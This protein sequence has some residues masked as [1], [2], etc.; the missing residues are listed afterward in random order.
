MR[1]LWDSFKL[2]PK[3]KYSLEH[4]KYL[5][6]VLTKNPVINDQNTGVIVETLRQVAELL[7]WGDQNNAG[8]L[9][10]FLEKNLLGFFFAIL[11]Q[12]TSRTVQIQLMQTLSIL[13]ENLRSQD[14]LF[15]LFSNN[16]INKVIIHKF[17]FSDEELLAYY[18]S[19]MKTLS[20]K[21]DR[22]TVQFFFSAIDNDFPLYT[23]AIKFFNHE[24]SMIRIAVRTLTLNVFRVEDEHMRRYILNSTAV[25]YFANI[26]WFV[27][28]QVL[29]LNQLVSKSNHETRRR[30]DDFVDDLLDQFYYTHDI[31]NLG[32]ED[33]NVVLSDHLM[34]NLMLPLLVGSIAPPEKGREPPAPNAEDR[35][36]PV[37]ALF[38]LAQVF[39]IYSYKPLVNTLASALIHPAP[40]ADFTSLMHIKPPPPPSLS[41]LGTRTAFRRFASTPNLDQMERDAVSGSPQQPRRSS[42]FM[43]PTPPGSPSLSASASSVT[44]PTPRRN[45]P[46]R[47]LPPA[48]SLLRSASATRL[49]SSAPPDPSTPSR[50]P[51]SSPERKQRG[52]QMKEVLLSYFDDDRT[53]LA[54]VCLFYAVVKNQA[55]EREL[56]EI[57][58]L[59]PYRLTRAKQLLEILTSGRSAHAR[60]KS[61]THAL[62]GMQITP[63]HPVLNGRTSTQ[64]A[65]APRTPLGHGHGPT[66]PL[67]SPET[68]PNK[69]DTA[70]QSQ[71]ESKT[72]AEEAPRLKRRK[73]KRKVDGEPEAEVDPGIVTVPDSQQREFS[74]ELISRLLHVLVRSSQFRLVTLQMTLLMLKELVYSEDSPP[75]LTHRQLLLLGEAYGNASDSIREVLAGTLGPIFLELFEEDL[76]T[77]H[78]VN[79]DHL[80][81]DASLLLPVSGTSGSRLDLT[82]RLPSGEAEKTQKAIQQFL[83]LRELKYALL[84]KRDDQ[85]PLKEPPPPSI[86]AKDQVTIN[87]SSAPTGI[88]SPTPDPSEPPST[89]PAAPHDPLAPTAPSHPDFTSAAATAPATPA[90]QSS[91]TTTASPNFVA[92]P[93]QSVFN[94]TSSTTH[95]PP[96]PALLISYSIGVTHPKDKSKRVRRFL[97]QY[98]RTL[99]VVDPSLKA[100]GIPTRIDAVCLHVAPLQSLEIEVDHT[101][102]TMLQI[103]SH[104]TTWSTTMIFDDSDGCNAAKDVLERARSSV[105]SSKM[106]QIYNILGEGATEGHAPLGSESED[107]GDESAT[108][109]EDL[110]RV[111]GRPASGEQLPFIPPSPTTP[112]SGGM[113]VPAISADPASSPN[114][115]SPSSMLNVLPVGSPQGPSVSPRVSIRVDSHPLAEEMHTPPPSPP[116]P[117]DDLPYEHPQAVPS[118]QGEE[119]SEP[120]AVKPADLEARPD[121]ETLPMDV[122]VVEP[123]PVSPDVGSAETPSIMV[124][125]EDEALLENTSKTAPQEDL[126]EVP[127]EQ[128]TSSPNTSSPP[129]EESDVS[130]TPQPSPPPSTTPPLAPSTLSHHDTPPMAEES[131]HS[132]S[133]ESKGT[134]SDEAEPEQQLEPE[135]ES[136]PEPESE[137]QPEPELH[138]TVDDTPFPAHVE[139]EVPSE[140]KEDNMN[141]DGAGVDDAAGDDEQEDIQIQNDGAKPRA[142]NPGE[143]VA[144]GK[145]KKKKGRGGRRR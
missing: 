36:S 145:K 80:I 41:N 118:Y 35:I 11:A 37:L 129:T 51:P 141:P 102:S 13:V 139:T 114:I 16:H 87:I 79:F 9:D 94:C 117:A 74:R 65:G 123:A 103:T 124:M 84:R 91:A 142:D 45:T 25:P 81:K 62:R 138:P 70:K 59:F 64:P 96:T 144:G 88:T 43:S 10:F 90:S 7:I 136:L 137:Q 58:G 135:P 21:L 49:D 120:E 3:N 67:S 101:D 18:V 61:D 5:H 63:G 122:H 34:Q 133:A 8:F 112:T 29:T 92:N 38:L 76:R 93:A 66:S 15:Y 31:F 26:V 68:S 52:N 40:T 30:L 19:F 100:S 83:V 89:L 24:E 110:D 105:R 104:Q 78:Q 53:A 85:L 119:K 14:A 17:D 2:K 55:V 125:N 47:P 143:T 6:T 54:L 60:S 56:L 57:G 82:R 72:K 127:S 71:A 77:Y 132:F 128:D 48:P 140:V 115:S 75:R 111:R 33:M 126:A 109:F 113:V 12:R 106:A 98:P 27:R 134:H 121:L 130:L 69:D 46:T 73:S 44:S 86:S 131:L 22:S 32:I 107:G 108:E 99:V 116:S 97:V 39:N 1:A 42:F 4:L 20:L 50:S 95:T 28:Q 23:E